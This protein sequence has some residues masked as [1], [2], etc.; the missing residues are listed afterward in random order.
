APRESCA[1]TPD[2]LEESHIDIEAVLGGG[3]DDEGKS[4]DVGEV[5]LETDQPHQTQRPQDAQSHRGQGQRAGPSR[6]QDYEGDGADHHERVEGALEVPAR[7][8][9]AALDVCD[10]RRGHVGI[11]RAQFFDEAACAGPLPDVDARVDAEQIAPTPADVPLPEPGR[12]LAR[13]DGLG[14]EPSLEP[15]ELV[16]E[17]LVQIAL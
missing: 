7:N 14:I 8:E 5:E 1:A 17:V 13:L 6:F 15:L 3:P 12:G 9:M 2:A 10:G 4:P 16:L 11:D